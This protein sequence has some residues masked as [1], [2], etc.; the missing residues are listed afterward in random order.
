MLVKN[1][2]RTYHLFTRATAIILL[3]AFVI[4]T[5]L[6][7][8]ELMEFCNMEM[9]SH[10]KMAENTHSDCQTASDHKNNDENQHDDCEFGLV[11]ACN[12][13]FSALSDKDGIVVSGSSQII[14]SESESPYPFTATNERIPFIHQHRINQH[15]P[16]LW[17]MYDT[18]LL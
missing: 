11:C 3:L 6:H 10:S 17:L 9:N 5:G 12:I 8:G 15:T 7:A 14:I 16:P 1:Y 13:G 2:S 18:F 4:P